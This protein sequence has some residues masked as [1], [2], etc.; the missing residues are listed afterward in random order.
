MY[1]LNMSL[2]SHPNFHCPVSI[3][4]HHLPRIS[5]V[6]FKMVFQLSLS[7]ILQHPFFCNSYSVALP[8]PPSLFFS[9]NILLLI[10]SDSVDSTTRRAACISSGPVWCFHSRPHLNSSSTPLS[11]DS[12]ACL[13]ALLDPQLSKGTVSYSCW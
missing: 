3:S 9:P 6:I 13:S 11:A 10:L 4:H 8:Q 2:L 5:T 12:F 7:T 1:L